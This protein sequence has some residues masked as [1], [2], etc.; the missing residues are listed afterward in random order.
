MTDFDGNIV[1]APNPNNHDP[2]YYYFDIAK[3]LPIVCKLFEKPPK[4]CKCHTR[5]DI[6]KHICASY[7]G[8]RN[9][10]DD[11][12]ECLEGPAEDAMR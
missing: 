11:V 7:Y 3:K 8:Y 2:N 6:Y 4:L 1:D 10:E 9:E 12:L 5:Y